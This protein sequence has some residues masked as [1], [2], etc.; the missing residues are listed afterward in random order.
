MYTEYMYKDSL[1]HH[2]IKGQRWGV[3]R[4]QNPDGT[5]TPEGRARYGIKDTD[6][7]VTKKVKTDLANMT[8]EQFRGKYQISKAKYMKRVDKYGDPYMNSPLAKAGKKLNAKKQMDQ[9]NLQAKQEMQ[10]KMDKNQEDYEKEKQLIK[11]G[12]KSKNM[13]K[14]ANDELKAIKADTDKKAIAK[15]KKEAQKE[16]DKKYDQ[17]EEL[18][19]I[20]TY[21]YSNGQMSDNDYE[22]FMSNLVD[23]EEELSKSLNE[24]IKTGKQP[25]AIT[26]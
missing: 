24:Y 23:A 18:A 6:S 9:K 22:E 12:S 21:K 26:I 14:V 15:R 4:Y 3:R 11:S 25:K 13:D 5:L 20:A 10:A 1:A 2:G 7:S 16:Y 19:N 17:L 8:E